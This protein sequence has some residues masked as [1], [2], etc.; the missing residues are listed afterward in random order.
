[1][2]KFLIV[3]SRDL[4][5]YRDGEFALELASQLKKKGHDATLFLVENAALAARKGSEAS[6]KLTALSR[7]GVEVLA[8]DLSLQIRGVSDRVEGVSESNMETLAELILNGV[9]KVLWY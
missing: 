6:S 3:E 1:M 9:D 4:M 2:A 8:E 5:E 7:E